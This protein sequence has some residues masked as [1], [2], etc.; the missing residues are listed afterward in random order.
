[1][2]P[3]KWFKCCW[4]YEK[5]PFGVSLLHSFMAECV[6]IKNNIQK[7]YSYQWRKFHRCSF[8][9]HFHS[10]LRLVVLHLIVSLP[11][12]LTLHFRHVFSIKYSCCL[13]CVSWMDP[14]ITIYSS[15]DHPF[16]SVRFSS[17]SSL[18]FRKLF[19]LLHL[20]KI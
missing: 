13:F 12:S 6:F 9:C 1:M 7:E 8:F 2:K 11:R 14:Y 5:T 17:I 19:L 20:W 3:F 4:V 10:E 16:G 18:Q 15:R